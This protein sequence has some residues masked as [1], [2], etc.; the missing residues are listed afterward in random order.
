MNNKLVVV[1]LGL[2]IV[3]GWRLTS[4]ETAPIAAGTFLVYD[5]SGTL[6]RLTFSPAE[7]ERFATTLE[8]ADDEGAFGS[9]ESWSSQGDA[10]N[11]RMRTESGGI[12][13]IGSLGPLWVPP[14]Q[15]HEGGNANGARVAEVLRWESWEVGVV[16]ANMGIGA[17]L[18]GEWFYDTQ[19]GFL[20]GGTKSTAVSGPGQGQ[21]FT[22]TD[23]NLPGL[24]P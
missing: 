6:M 16:R 19:S 20:V 3:V 14:G 9:G 8:G 2:A 10:V 15:L 24:A 21:V 13:E 12:F 11:G 1:L 5:V 4:S 7:G 23:T 17:A 18:R 22:L